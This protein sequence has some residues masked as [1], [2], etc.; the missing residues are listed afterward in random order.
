MDGLEQSSRA[1][2]RRES[3]PQTDL[4]PFREAARKP[5]IKKKNK[6]LESVPAEDLWWVEGNEWTKAIDQKS[7]QV[8][9]N[10]KRH[11]HVIDTSASLGLSLLQ[12]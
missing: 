1:E 6:I 10:N 9:G 4:K 2:V 12:A 8:N 5:E 11:T 7:V 3:K